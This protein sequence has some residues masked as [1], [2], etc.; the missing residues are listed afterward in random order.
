MYITIKKTKIY[1]CNY[2]IR[3]LIKAEGERKMQEKVEKLVT[4]NLGLVRYVAKQ[5]SSSNVD[6]DDLVSEGTMGLIKA[7]SSFDETKNVKFSTYSSQCIRNEILMYLR[8]ENKHLDVKSIDDILS[9]DK[10][11]NTFVLSEIIAD[12][13]NYYEDR[14]TN[15]VLENVLN[16]ILNLKDTKKRTVLLLKSA[17]V[18]QNKIGKDLG[19]S[20]SY[21]S[22]IEKKMKENLQGCIK[23][24]K[25]CDPICD[26]RKIDELYKITFYT[27]KLRSTENIVR[28]VEDEARKVGLVYC[29]IK[30]VKGIYFTITIL[31]E[32]NSMVFL[33]NL[34]NQ[35]A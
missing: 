18:K 7:A 8:K 26:C 11:G 25:S 22:R 6:F 31:N 10:D 5:F 4:N 15:E 20:Q 32:D 28:I 33:A 30:E 13:S 3:Y 35:I 2:L 9:E 16:W 14:D 12:K 29:K 24:K 23:C 19:F 17:G 34:L 1:R 21:I 27:P